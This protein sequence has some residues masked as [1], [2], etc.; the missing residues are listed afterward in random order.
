MTVP[1]LECCVGRRSSYS[2]STNLSHQLKI[3]TAS[4]PDTSVP[5]IQQL[6]SMINS[7]LRDV[8]IDLK[9]NSL[10]IS[11]PKSTVTLFTQ[12]HNSSR[13]SQR[14]L[15]KIHNIPLERNPKLLGT[16]MDPSLSF[17]FAWQ[18][19][20]SV[21]VPPL[22]GCVGRRSSYSLSTYFSQQ[23]K[24]NTAADPDISIHKI[25]QLESMINS[26]QRDVGIDLKENSLLISAPIST[27]ILFTWK[28]NSSRRFQRFTLEDAQLLLERCPKILGTIMDPS[29]SF[30][31]YCN[32]VTYRIDKRNNILNAL[33]GLSLGQD[34]EPLLLTY[35]ALGKSIASYDAPIRSTN[36]SNSSFK[37]IQTAQNAA[38]K[39]A[40]GGPYTESQGQIRHV[41]C[42]APC[43]LSGGGPRL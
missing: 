3:K 39:T 36:A 9:E 18:F 2:L 15:L 40:T 25:Q 27:V 30:H 21:T 42:A 13:R 4:D 24:I 7:Y 26:Y 35:N 31:K 41:L 16:I 5:K 8:G 33:A 23:L 12:T 17:H 20:T 34:K 11:A 14:L 38:L 37:K 6:E 28:H 10:L 1:P 43:E 29:L 19:V 22:E 32:Y